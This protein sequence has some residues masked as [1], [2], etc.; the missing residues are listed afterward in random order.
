MNRLKQFLP[1]LNV[2]DT[3]LAW[4]GLSAGTI[5]IIPE[6]FLKLDVSFK[7]SQPILLVTL[8][9]SLAYF[10]SRLMVRVWSGVEGRSKSRAKQRDIENLVKCLDHCERA[11]LREFVISRRSVLSLPLSEPSVA[12]L[13]HNGVLE[14]VD[15]EPVAEGRQMVDCVIS[16][17]ARPLLSFRVLSLPVGKLS[18]EQLDQLKR[19]RPQ[20][21]QPEYLANRTHSGKVFRIRTVHHDEGQ[22]AA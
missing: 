3:L 14:R 1:T 8:V 10:L 18:E 5:L 20:F 22:S 13:I 15:D 9:A 16:L 21:L 6:G 2:V 12:N 4:I 17:A 7:S 11:V 19:M